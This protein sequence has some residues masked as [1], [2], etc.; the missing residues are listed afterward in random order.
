MKRWIGFTNIVTKDTDATN[1]YESR[2][3]KIITSSLHSFQ[4]EMGEIVLFT[5][6]ALQNTLLFEI[7]DGN[8]SDGPDGQ[9]SVFDFIT[10]LRIDIIVLSTD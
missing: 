6:H 8:G 1:F 10:I 9:E 4:C 3:S 7:D 2:T 5:H